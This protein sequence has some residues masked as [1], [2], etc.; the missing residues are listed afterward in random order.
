MEKF[1]EFVD[2]AN[3]RDQDSHGMYIYNDWN[4]YG[5]TELMENIMAGF[6]AIVF[7]KDVSPLKKWAYVE[8]LAAFVTM[9][10]MQEWMSKSTERQSSDFKIAGLKSVTEWVQGLSTK[11][12]SNTSNLFFLNFSELYTLP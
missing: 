2:E 8:G 9:V 12:T 4:G 5:M 11:S 6:N 10:G 3:K 7:K 1:K